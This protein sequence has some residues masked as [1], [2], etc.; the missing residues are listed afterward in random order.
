[1][2]LGTWALSSIDL[3]TDKF[4][5]AAVVAAW[6]ASAGLVA[7]PLICVSQE[8]MTPAQVASSAG[9]KNLMLSLP[10][11]VGGNLMTIFIERRGDAHFDSMRQSIVPNRPPWD[12]V[13]L[14]VIDDFILHGADPAEAA[15]AASRLLG[16]WTRSHANV[17]AY[18]SAFQILALTI[19]SA[20][21]LALLLK[22]LPPHAPGPQRG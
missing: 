14:G 7:S 4:W 5:T 8:D 22:P 13:K 9:I 1:M 10:A 15:A 18:Q 6:A 12:D 16:G 19:A 2:T 20:V 11:F 17:F 3:Y 21:V